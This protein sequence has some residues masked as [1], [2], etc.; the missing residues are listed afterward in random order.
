[1]FA[2]GAPG[3]SG[4]RSTNR[5]ENKQGRMGGRLDAL[6]LALVCSLLSFATPSLPVFILLFILNVLLFYFPTS[7]LP[8]LPFPSISFLPT[9]FSFFNFFFCYY[10]CN[11]LRPLPTTSH[12]SSLHEVFPY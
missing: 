6:P 2:E 1:M 7:S 8:F 11:D 4:A 12:M 10:I 3:P 9:C 5:K